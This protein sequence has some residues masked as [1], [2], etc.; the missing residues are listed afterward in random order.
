MP[1]TLGGNR[2]F[3]RNKEHPKSERAFRG[4]NFLQEELCGMD[5]KNGERFGT[6]RKS[7]RKM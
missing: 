2:E 7:R 4:K 6:R 1:D 5:V 3:G